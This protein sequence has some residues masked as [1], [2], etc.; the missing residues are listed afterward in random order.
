MCP[1][2]GACADGEGVILGSRGC[3]TRCNSG[4]KPEEEVGRLW[5]RWGVRKV[6]EG[7]NSMETSDA[8]RGRGRTAAK[9]Q[10]GS[11]EGTWRVP[12]DPGDSSA[13]LVF[14]GLGLAI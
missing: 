13:G 9:L 1:G 3:W 11:A 6:R 12:A 10:R 14:P 2:P 7:R 5:G 4:Q 8:S